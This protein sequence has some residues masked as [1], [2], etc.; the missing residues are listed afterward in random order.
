MSGKSALMCAGA[1]LDLAA[2]QPC[3]TAEDG[4]GEIV[5]TMDGQVV[6]GGLVRAEAATEPDGLALL[7]QVW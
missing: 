4:A 2:V 5:S 3:G 6:T 7:R 1:F